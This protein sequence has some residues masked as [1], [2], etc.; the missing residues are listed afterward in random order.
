MAVPAKTKYLIEAHNNQDIL[1][2][3]EFGHNQ[4]IDV[5]VLGEGSN[6]LFT[7]D[8][9]G[10]VILNRLKGISVV[11]QN[12]ET[13]TVNIKAGENWHQ[14][15]E[16]A[17]KQG[18]YG[19]ENLA[20]IPGLVGAAPI[21]NIGAYG[22]EIKDYI[23]QVNVIDLTT[24]ESQQLD[25]SQC[26][27]G[28]RDSIFKQSLK[29]SSIITSVTLKLNRR[30]TPNLSYPS[31]QHKLK[32]S[33]QETLT[34][35]QVFNAVCDIRLSKLPLPASIPNLGSF[36]KNPII[37]KTKF[38]EIQKQHNDLVAFQQDEAVKLAAGWLIESSGWKQKCINDITVYE[39]QALVIINP[40]HR[41]G[42]HVI[43]FAREIQKDIKLKF[44]IDLEVEP[45]IY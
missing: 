12:E 16:F 28:Y 29:Y 11:E 39:H 42:D 35:K 31:L 33:E 26:K 14:F 24:G 36:F 5:L 41:T 38:T 44:G 25:H 30:F 10:L 21:Q 6:T 1:S 18:W 22:V 23:L 15:V 2:A 43:H 34:A 3:I 19:L 4:D 9:D 40:K 27:F 13:V 37:A 8:Y 20:L 45:Q 32:A 17:I 7:K